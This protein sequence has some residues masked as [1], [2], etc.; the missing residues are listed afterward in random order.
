MNN[1]IPVSTALPSILFLFILQGLFGILWQIKTFACVLT[2]TKHICAQLVDAMWLFE[3][4]L[5]MPFFT[6]EEQTLK[7]SIAGN[8]VSFPKCAPK[9]NLQYAD[10]KSKPIPAYKKKYLCI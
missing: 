9:L 10:R 4:L 1:I 7:R 6:P 3:P 5:D 8:A 2:Q